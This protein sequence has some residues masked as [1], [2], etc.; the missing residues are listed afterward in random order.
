MTAPRA[1]WSV[2]VQASELRQDLGAADD[3]LDR[4][5][6][7]AAGPGQ[8]DDA[9]GALAAVRHADERDADAR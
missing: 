4:E 1:R 6:A 2:W 8:P 9:P 5:Q 3:R 7:R